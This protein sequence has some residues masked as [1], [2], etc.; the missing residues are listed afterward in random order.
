M[1]VRSHPQQNHILDAL[2]QGERERLFPYLKLVALPLGKAL[3]E[4]GDWLRHIYIPS[5]R[6]DHIPTRSNTDSRRGGLEK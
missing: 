3:Y 4:S 1:A 5:G 2:P 6:F